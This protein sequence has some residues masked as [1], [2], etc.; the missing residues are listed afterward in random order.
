MKTRYWQKFSS[1]I[2]LKKM[3]GTKK[4]ESFHAESHAET[5]TAIRV[6][7]LTSLSTTS[8]HSVR[9]GFEQSYCSRHLSVPGEGITTKNALATTTTREVKTIRL[10]HIVHRC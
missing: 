7:E 1:A 8:L 10:K 4:G 6:V 9:G 2:S 3:P 5:D